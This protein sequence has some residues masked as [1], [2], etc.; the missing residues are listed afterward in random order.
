MEQA[1]YLAAETDLLD[2]CR[3]LLTMHCDMEHGALLTS[4]MKG[5]F[6]AERTKLSTFTEQRNTSV[7]E[8]LNMPDEALKSYENQFTSVPD[9][10]GVAQELR[11]FYEAL[12]LLAISRGEG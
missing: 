1:G 2:D 5:I 8:L 6:V 11:S 12:V 9:Q 4:I 7:I 3:S 10:L